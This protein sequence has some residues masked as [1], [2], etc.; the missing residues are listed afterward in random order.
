MRGTVK[1]IVC[2]IVLGFFLLVGVDICLN[3]AFGVLGFAAA[4]SIKVASKSKHDRGCFTQGVYYY[5]DYLYES[6]GLTDKSQFRMIDS[7]GAVVKSFKFAS[8]IFA[9]GIVVVNDILYVLT[10]KNRK[11]FVF[12]AT[13]LTPIG[14]QSFK[15]K[16]NEGWGLAADLTSNSLILSDGS[17]TLSFYDIPVID[18]S[19]K[20]AFSISNNLGIWKLQ[21][22]LNVFRAGKAVKHINE[23]EF[24]DNYLYA[25]VWYKNFI[26]KV[27]ISSGNVVD[28]FDCE[29]LLPKSREADVLNGIAYDAALEQFYIT[30]KLWP[31]AYKLSLKTTVGISASEPIES[32][33]G[34]EGITVGG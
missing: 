12:D 19:Q 24:V 4:G 29:P 13:T 30:G 5:G 16:T 26:I 3:H 10:W 6:C 21:R 14:Y 2:N 32:L 27:D 8:D 33:A 17:S 18:V 23:L 25:N 11:I 31:V 28:T 1:N 9:E 7:A 22:Q 34:V 15:S 20:A